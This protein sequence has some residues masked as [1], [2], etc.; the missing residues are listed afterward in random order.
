MKDNR[1]VEIG[2]RLRKLRDETGLSQKVLAERA[3]ISENTLARLERGEHLI[4]QETTEKLAKALD[5]SSSDIL[6]Y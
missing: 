3:G 5:V 4:A 6:G 1:T 2:K